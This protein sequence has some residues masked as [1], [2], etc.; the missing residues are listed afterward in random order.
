MKISIADTNETLSKQIADD[1]IQLIGKK[2]HPVLC[3]AS[4]DSPAGLYKE[5]VKRVHQ[6]LLDV[7]N[8]Y[9]VGLDEWVGMN[10]ND[11]GSCRYHLDQQLFEP[12]KVGQDKLSFFDGRS[13]NKELECKRVESF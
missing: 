3:T 4:G 6:N 8:W 2:E 11:E 9:F 1:L 5:L 13:E 10:G 7:S 12:L